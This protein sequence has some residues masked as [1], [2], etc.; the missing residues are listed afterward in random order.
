VPGVCAFTV[1]RRFIPEENIADVK[2]EIQEAIDRGM[3]KSRALDVEVQY[4]EMYPSYY[5]SATHPGARRLVE[6]LKLVQGYSD[7]DFV[8]TGSGGSTD[9][10]F[11]AQVL[12]TDEIATVGL[13]RTQESKAHGANES[14]RLTDAK[15]H[16]KEL[17]YYFC[18]PVG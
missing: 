15:A 5:Q 8:E 7:E 6:A 1:N 18:A 4:V 14:V 9:M 11:V 13:G 10:A 3:E 16:V 2:A 12:G 17:I